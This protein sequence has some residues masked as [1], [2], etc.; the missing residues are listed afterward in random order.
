[1]CVLWVTE[2]QPKH[3]EVSESRYWSNVR[4]IIVNTLNTLFLICFP[5]FVPRNL[6]AVFFTW[7]RTGWKA[8]WP[9]LGQSCLSQMFL[10]IINSW[11]AFLWTKS[12][13]VE[14]LLCPSV[15]HSIPYFSQSCHSC[16]L[17]R[18]NGQKIPWVLLNGVSL[19][20]QVRRGSEDFQ[21]ASDQNVPQNC[22]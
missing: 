17:K 19:E 21:W 16:F 15:F 10:W 22:F 3:D 11:L 6:H 20:C 14:F 18:W 5:H 2:E 13:H 8:L 12:T 4:N 9:H 7:F 1:M